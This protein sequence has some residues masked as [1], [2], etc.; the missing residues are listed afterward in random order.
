MQNLGESQTSTTLHMINKCPCLSRLLAWAIWLLGAIFY[1]YEFLI[2]VAPNVMAAELMSHFSIHATHLG[3]LTSAYFF[4]YMLMQ[5]PA[6]MLLDKFG[7]RR[8]MTV[9]VLFCAIGSIS[10]ATTHLFVMA[11]FARFLTGVGSA[12]AF[13]GTLVLTAN[14]F[15]AKNFAFLSGLLLTVGMLG[16]IFGEAPLAYLVIHTSWQSS[17]QILG[18]SGIILALV[19]WLVIRDHHPNKPK[20]SNNMTLK[21]LLANTLRVLSDKNAWITASYGCLMFTPTICLGAL[22]GIPFLVTNHGVSKTHAGLLISLLFAGWAVGSPL[23]GRYSDWL[24]KR[25]PPLYIA[26]IGAFFTLL[27]VM[28]LPTQSGLLLAILLFLLG[29]FSSGFIPAF[30]ICRELYPMET[31]GTAL[32]F[33]NMLNSF[34]PAVFSPLVGLILDLSWQGQQTAAGI[35]HYSPVNYDIALSILPICLLIALIL[36]PFL[37][38]THAKIHLAE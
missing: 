1:F 30:S 14:W 16:A 4:A 29:F 20:Q 11:G 36:I 33:M 13:L 37:Q 3:L 15:P 5:L 12:F 19:M 32:G 18:V 22:W 38:E 2:Q 23:F 8:L 35:R 28:Y 21:R 26:S 17:L 31:S 34:G 6:G 24:K 25:K 10:F 7:P 9:A 27:T